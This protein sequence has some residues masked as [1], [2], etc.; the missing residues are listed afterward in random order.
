MSDQS[1]ELFVISVSQPTD[2]LLVVALAGEMD[3]ANAPQLTARLAELGTA[4]QDRVVIDLSKLTFIDS[5]GINALVSAAKP[6]EAAGG[7][8][9]VAAP[10]P[11][12]QQ[13]FDIVHLSEVVP[14]EQSLEAALARAAH[15]SD[16]TAS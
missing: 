14:I 7:R 5:S 8:V 2:G 12:I 11:H 16:R 6:I 10:S 13:V 15:D 3:I 4:G 9:I 1:A